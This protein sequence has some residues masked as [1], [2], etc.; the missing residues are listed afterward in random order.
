MT[1]I[2]GPTMYTSTGRYVWPLRPDWFTP[3]IT[4]IADHLSK[5]NRFLGATRVPYSV[6]EHSVR[7]V[8]LL[9][10]ELQLAGLLHDASEAYLGDMPSYLK[11]DPEFGEPYRRAERR[12]SARIEKVFGVGLDHDLIHWADRRLLATERRDLLS[13][14]DAEWL[15]LRGVKP[16]RGRIVPWGWVEARDRFLACFAELTLA[17]AA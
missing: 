3:D 1:V 14:D 6:A 7:V 9:P 2:D 8:E 4:E 15:V 13:H 16:L 5:I 10:P 11:R 17:V 12:L